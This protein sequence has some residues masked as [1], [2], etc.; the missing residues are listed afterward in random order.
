MTATWPGP[1]A[2]K[3][4]QITSPPPHCSFANP[5]CAALFFFKKDR[6]SSANSSK[7]PYLFRVFLLTEA[8]RVWVVA[9]GFLAVSLSIAQF[10]IGGELA[11]TSTP[12]KINNCPE[13]FPLVNN[14]CRCRMVDS[15]LFANYLITPLRL[16]GSNSCFS[17]II[18]DVFP[19]WHCVNTHLNMLQASKL[20]KLLLF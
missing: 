3:R 11:G 18:A 15:W 17:K 9:L 13:C 19:P 1:M 20:T 16:L 5:S 2:A 6:L 4:A 10:D 8:R 14:L 7:K 12:L